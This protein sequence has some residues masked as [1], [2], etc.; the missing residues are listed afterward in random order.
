MAKKD[1]RLYLRIKPELK[2]QVKEYCVR[3]HTTVSDV[4]TRFFVR[5]LKADEEEDS[6]QI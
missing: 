1:E 4:V 3:N 6:E 5:L 2:E